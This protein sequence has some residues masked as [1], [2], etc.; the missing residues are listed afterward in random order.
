MTFVF[1]ILEMRRIEI[2]FMLGGMIMLS[3][4]GAVVPCLG[5]CGNRKG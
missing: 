5:G 2:I 1:P 4:K 3:T